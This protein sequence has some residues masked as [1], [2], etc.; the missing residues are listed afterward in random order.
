MTAMGLAYIHRHDDS[1]ICFD[2]GCGQYTGPADGWRPAER[3]A[4]IDASEVDLTKLR[5][6][7]CRDCG[8]PAGN[9]VDAIVAQ[10]TELDPAAFAELRFRLNMLAEIEDYGLEDGQGTVAIVYGRN[11]KYRI[12]AKGEAWDDYADALD[13]A[14]ILYVDEALDPERTPLV[15]IALRTGLRLELPV[16]TDI[17]A[18]WDRAP[19]PDHVAWWQYAKGAVGVEAFCALCGGICNPG[20]ADDMTHGVR[21]DGEPCG[22]PLVPVAWW[23]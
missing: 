21:D 10:A 3:Q 5:F 18:R 12:D 4:I 15:F 11:G 1:A 20:G 8:Q 23:A 13:H 6:G 17:D 19:Q 9:P 7:E 2:G 14:R 16:I 22:G